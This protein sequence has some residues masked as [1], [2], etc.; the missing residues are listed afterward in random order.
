MLP[1]Y[2]ETRKP[3]IQTNK[4]VVEEYQLRIARCCNKLTVAQNVLIKKIN[5][6]L[7]ELKKS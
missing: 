4:E 1:R 3:K 6:G 5:D 7:R 2:M